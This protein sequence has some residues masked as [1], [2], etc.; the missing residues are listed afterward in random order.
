VA[1]LLEIAAAELGLVVELV[2]VDA[3]AA[4]AG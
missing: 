4:N 3:V 2:F 1:L